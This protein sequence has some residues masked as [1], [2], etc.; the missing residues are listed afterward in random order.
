MWNVEK[1]K[2]LQQ[3]LRI[4]LHD[5]RLPETVYP[6]GIY[7]VETAQAVRM[8]QQMEGLPQTGE[9]DLDTWNTVMRCSREIQ[10]RDCILPLQVFPNPDFQL[11]PGAGG[12]LVGLV[13]GLLQKLSEIYGNIPCPNLTMQYDFLTEQAVSALQRQGALPVT[14][15]LDRLTWNLLSS[16]YGLSL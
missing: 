8:L 1:I 7:G 16:L 9:V 5:R 4:I 14:G 3:A 12:L 15:I 10:E 6:D 13:Q 2:E 11:Q